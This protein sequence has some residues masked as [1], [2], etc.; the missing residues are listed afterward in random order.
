MGNRIWEQQQLCPQ[1]ESIAQRLS[2]QEAVTL[3]E[4]I[5]LIEVTIMIE[6]Y[7]TPEQ[8][9]QLATRRA[10]LGQERIREVE[11]E[12]QHLIE[13]VRIE[14]V[15]GQDPSSESV[16]LLAQHWLSLIQEFTGGD[17]GIWKSLQTMY[18]QEGAPQASQGMLDPEVM[19]F[20]GKALAV[21]QSRSQS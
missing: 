14:M 6:K 7:Y 19:E 2:V 1:L 5:Q 12:W 20:M 18:Q 13:Q 16:Q 10:E 9:D 4:L 17:A 15:A 3:Q 11:V 8:L 21:L